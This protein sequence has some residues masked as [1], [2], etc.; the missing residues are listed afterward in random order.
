MPIFSEQREIFQ[1]E[2]SGGAYRAYTYTI[3]SSIVMVPVFA[4]ISIVANL[5]SY[6]LIGLP[7][8]ASPIIFQT[9]ILFTGFVAANNFATMFSVLIPSPITGSSIATSLFSVMFLLCGFFI[10]SNY[11][12][13]TYLSIYLPTYLSTYLSIYLPI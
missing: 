3:A 5:M 12:L 11:Y 9:F 4:W 13:S 1:R 7:N 2:Y 6:W 10:T 8:H